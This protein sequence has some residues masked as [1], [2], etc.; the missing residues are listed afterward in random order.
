MHKIVSVNIVKPM[1]YTSKKNLDIIKKLELKKLKNK[2]KSFLQKIDYR[3][4]DD[5]I[6]NHNYKYHTHMLEKLE[7][8]CQVSGD[9]ILDDKE[10]TA[11]DFL[12]KYKFDE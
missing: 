3:F 1:L 12:Y 8:M 6:V 9:I 2:K 11:L 10:F 4:D 7:I 5:F